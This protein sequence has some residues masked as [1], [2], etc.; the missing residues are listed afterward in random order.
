[1][2]L[3]RY[4]S[5]EAQSERKRASAQKRL[6]NMYYQSVERMGAAQEMA[7]LAQENDVQALQILLQ[8]FEHM[9]PSATI[10]RDEKDYVVELLAGIGSFAIDGTR[11]YVRKTTEAIFWPMRFLQKVLDEEDFTEFLAEVLAAT[12][13]DYTRDPKKKLGLVQLAGEHHNEAVK[14]EILRFVNDYDES[15]RFHA[16]DVALRLE[17]DGA[18]ETLLERWVS[19]KE[20]SGRIWNQLADAFI[21]RGWSVGDQANAVKARLPSGATVGANGIVQR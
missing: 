13:E 14:K 20:E 11:E 15:I 3:F 21:T 6:S 18:R 17:I 16:I 19:P 9:N 2:G 5:K 7:E 1:M 10:D 4:F 8:R 12:S